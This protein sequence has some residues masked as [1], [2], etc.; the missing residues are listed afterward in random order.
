[1][2]AINDPQNPQQVVPADRFGD[3]EDEATFSKLVADMNADYESGRT[4]SQSVQRRLFLTQRQRSQDYDQLSLAE[5]LAR[6]KPLGH[7]DCVSTF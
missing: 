7:Q 5:L 2:C 6:Y 4:I 1:M 3:G